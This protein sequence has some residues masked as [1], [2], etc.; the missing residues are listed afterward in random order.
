MTAAKGSSA[1]APRLRAYVYLDRMQPNWA[2]Y[3]A[4]TSQDHAPSAGMAQLYIEV[5]PAMLVFP[6]ANEAL[7]NTDTRSAMLVA[8]RE[9]GT[10]EL[11]AHD[12]DV[13]K[14]AGSLMLN[15]I[16]GS[17]GAA[18]APSAV[19]VHT[20]ANVTDSEAQLINK[21]RVPN[22]LIENDAMLIVEVAP[23]AYVALAANEAEKHTALRLILVVLHGASGR[24]ML[25]GTESEVEIGRGVTLDALGADDA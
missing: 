10:I 9:F 2:A 20:V 21:M 15:R 19:H 22:L 23:A 11:H 6:L 24:L 13:V 5:A 1:S 3:V 14:Q 16:G 4:Q 8:E 12:P 17:A 7:K 18:I 25:A